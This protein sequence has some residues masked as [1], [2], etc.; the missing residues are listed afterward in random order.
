MKIKKISM[1]EFFKDIM[2]SDLEERAVFQIDLGKNDEDEVIY[3]YFNKHDGK[4]VGIYHDI[5][6]AEEGDYYMVIPKE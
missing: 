4:L 5:A 1:S 6:D 2:G 3:H